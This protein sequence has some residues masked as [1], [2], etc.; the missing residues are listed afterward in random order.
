MESEARAR[1]VHA[2]VDGRNVK[3]GEETSIPIPR[4]DSGVEEL[5][6]ELE[7][8][9]QRV[10]EV[11]IQELEREIDEAVYDLFDLTEDEREVLKD[12]SEVF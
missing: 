7:D 12:Y 1:Y 10:D 4:S 8:D 5:L 9:R 3:K 6:Q 2:A 11:D